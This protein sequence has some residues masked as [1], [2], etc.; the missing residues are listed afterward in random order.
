MLKV[1]TVLI[2]LF[3]GFLPKAFSETISWVDDAG[4][5]H[6]TEQM[7]SVP[8]KYRNRINVREDLPKETPSNSSKLSKS[9]HIQNQNVS[10]SANQ[11]A[12]HASSGSSTSSQAS[13][14]ND[15]GM[16]SSGSVQFKGNPLP[17]GFREAIHGY[18]KDRQKEAYESQS[19]SRKIKTEAETKIYR[20]SDSAQQS[21]N[22]A[23]RAQ[24]SAQDLVNKARNS[25]MNRK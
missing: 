3:I 4:G 1:M 18:T 13:D 5:M 2:L 17:P 11:N 7:S 9:Q 15:S 20:N 22:Q 12:S 23:N 16:A 21:R 19:E 6:F 10:Y 14:P 25:N 8:K 24:Q